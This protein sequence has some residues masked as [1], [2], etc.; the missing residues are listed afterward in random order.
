MSTTAQ[1]EF[2]PD[3]DLLNAFAEHVLDERERSHV[4]AHLASCGRCRQVLTLA[5]QAAG[6]EV[7]ELV[8]AA[9]PAA[10]FA[11]ATPGPARRR[12]AWWQN[13]HFAWIPIAA[14]AATV[15][16]A[17]YLHVAR[18]DHT[19]EVARN[20]PAAVQPDDVTS[21]NPA[22]Q[23]D[24][25]A[26]TPA[27][28]PGATAKAPARPSVP[29]QAA[30]K[31]AEPAPPPAA[32]PPTAPAQ[33][34]PSATESVVVTQDANAPET[35]SAQ[36]VTRIEPRPLAQAEVSQIAGTGSNGALARGQLKAE[37][38]EELGERAGA[39]PAASTQDHFIVSAGAVAPQAA[40][41]S[42]RASAKDTDA[43]ASVYR[44][45]SEAHAN[46]MATF[47]SLR[48]AEA[49]AG[50]SA[51]PIH[52]PSGL[53]VISIASANHLQ[54]ALD[55]AG[56][57]FLSADAGGTWQQISSRWT[58]RA[59]L[60]R[61]RPS[62][63]PPSAASPSA[64]T[65]NGVAGALQEAPQPATIFEIVNDRHRLWQSTDGINWIAK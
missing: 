23:R 32:L 3:A 31:K 5:Q 13:W 46:S 11:V 16:F 59:I 27:S 65:S 56:T 35:V 39:T 33:L 25:K 57:L 24:A 30:E 47:G 55:Q 44:Q 6:I 20:T 12:R 63:A 8:A 64:A 60:V 15:T 36:Q 42:S 41:A 2:H 21:A 51:A 62:T 26:L 9:A 18:V 29:S 34:P 54:L 22:A 50:A 1:H 38:K 19:A 58:G 17:V 45:K 49:A 48:G 53:A 40:P 43:I 14:L 4:L 10:A 61:T 52:L 28:I 7:E 37:P